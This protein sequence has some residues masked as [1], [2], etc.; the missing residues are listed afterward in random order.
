MRDKPLRYFIEWAYD[1]K[2][3]QI[4]GLERYMMERYDITANAP[5][6][7]SN[8]QMR[9]MLQALLAERFQMKSHFEK[10]D[11]S[12][13]ARVRG[14]GDPTVKKEDPSATSG[15]GVDGFVKL[16]VNERLNVMF[17]LLPDVLALELGSSEHWLLLLVWVSQPLASSA[18]R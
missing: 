13:Y 7:A 6:P 1:L 16:E 12:V 9:P 10:R 4:A 8:D 5:G 3:Y 2:D 11:L 18:K 14:K 17:R 15:F